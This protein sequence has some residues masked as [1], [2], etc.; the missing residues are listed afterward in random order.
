MLYERFTKWIPYEK[1]IKNEDSSEKCLTY[2]TGSV[3]HGSGT[4]L[5]DSGSSKNMT[6]CKYSFS[7]LT[8]KYYPHK[9][10]LGYDYQYPIKGMGESSYK[11]KTRNSMKMK[12]VLYV[13]GL[14]KNII[15]IASLDKKGF[16]VSF[17]DSEV[18][19]WMKWKTID[20]AVV[21][22]VEEGWLYKLK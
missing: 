6:G 12:E 18:I 15:S 21:I 14:K 9:V 20:N 5:I 11:I 4:W 7:C 8:Q 19:M 13:P 17:I 1:T 16:I 22:G 10:Q 2:L 3:S